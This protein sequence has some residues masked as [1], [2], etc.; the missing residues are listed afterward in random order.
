ME[1]WAPP[2]REL[3]ENAEN[4]AGTRTGHRPTAGVETEEDQAL[5][6]MDVPGGSGSDRPEPQNFNLPGAANPCSGQP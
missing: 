4:A 5:G 2:A 6:Q 1:C 3:L